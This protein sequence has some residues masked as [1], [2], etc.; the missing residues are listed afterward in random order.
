MKSTGIIKKNF[1]YG[2]L[3]ALFAIPAT[4]LG[5]KIWIR[6]DA[7]E[8]AARAIKVF[9]K[10]KVESLLLS[11]DSDSFLIREKNDAIWALGTF[12]DKRA[13]EKMESL[14]THEKCSYGHLCQYEIQKAIL[15]IR[16]DYIALWKLD[17]GLYHTIRK[18]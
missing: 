3:I 7:N 13:L 2:M 5:L 16:R 6:H 12:K 8:I 18:R 9:H 15:K 11:L 17:P 1:L 10:D 4:Y 14:V